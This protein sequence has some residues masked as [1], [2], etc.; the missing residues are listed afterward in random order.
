MESSKQRVTIA[1]FALG[2]HKVS[3]VSNVIWLLTVVLCTKLK[4][5]GKFC[6]GLKGIERLECI[7]M[8]TEV[9]SQLSGNLHLFCTQLCTVFRR[10]RRSKKAYTGLPV[11]RV[12]QKQKALNWVV[13]NCT[14]TLLFDAFL[15]LLFPLCYVVCE[16]HR[17]LPRG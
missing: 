12:T 10:T 15:P 5:N 9:A 6:T 4:S 16:F 7:T 11:A 17:F 8:F 3:F 13:L 14:V 2:Y 1:S